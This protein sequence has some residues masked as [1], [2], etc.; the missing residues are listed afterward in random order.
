MKW[1]ET[2]RETVF[3]F[4]CACYVPKQRLGWLI[5]LAKAPTQTQ[6]SFLPSVFSQCT[7][8]CGQ[9]YQMRAVKCVV[10]TY[11]SVVDDNECNAATRP[12]D[13]QVSPAILSPSFPS[14]CRGIQAAGSGDILLQQ[15]FALNASPAEQ[16]LGLLHG[17]W[18]DAAQHPALVEIGQLNCV[19]SSHPLI[20]YT[21]KHQIARKTMDNLWGYQDFVAED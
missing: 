4:C 11:V 10:G 21:L 8:T 16:Y 12:T 9:G 1:R 5:L 18:K 3:Y 7:V 13:T 17:C 20:P 2:R 19:Q 15:S 14:V 6:C